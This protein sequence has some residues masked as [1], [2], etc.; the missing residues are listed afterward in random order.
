MVIQF[1]NSKGSGKNKLPWFGS[2][3][4]PDLAFLTEQNVRCSPS[5]IEH[6]VTEEKPK[7]AA[8]MEAKLGSYFCQGPNMDIHVRIDCLKLKK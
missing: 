8:K 6:F 1:V 2:R 4:A 7:M 5:Y 3:F